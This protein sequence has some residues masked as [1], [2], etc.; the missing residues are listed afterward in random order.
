MCD[1]RDLNQTLG[2][3]EQDLG[4]E[5]HRPAGRDR[6]ADQVGKI[7]PTLFLFD[8]QPGGVGL[9]E[10]IFERSSELLARTK[11]HIQR[12]PCPSGCP[13]CVGPTESEEGS[14]KA[15]SLALLDALGF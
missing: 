11:E 4:L 6:G 7:D 3:G 13:A 2:D 14:R 9:S 1:P 5:S 12:C 8:A 10:R 15:L